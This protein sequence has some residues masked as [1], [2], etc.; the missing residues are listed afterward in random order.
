MFKT[1]R[2]P[3]RLF[4]VAM[5]LVSFLFAGF[6]IGLGGKIVGD[7][8]GVE[9]RLSVEQFL[10][11]GEAARDGVVRDSLSRLA[12]GQGA[13]RER[14]QL[15]LAAAA[16]AYRNA[17]STF[18]NWIAARQATTDPSQD[19]EVLQRT[20]E[21]DALKESERSA[22][23]EMN[24]LNGEQ[25]S[26]S[27]AIEEQRARFAVQLRDASGRYE[28]ARFWQELRVF[29]IRLLITLP[30]LLV[31]AWLV[32]RKRKSQ[33]WPLARGFVLFALFTFFVELVPYLPSYGGY[34]RYGVGVIASG[35]AGIYVIRAM[36]R[37]KARRAEEEQQTESERRRALPYEEANKRI[38][39]GVCPACERSIATSAAGAPA[40]FC[41]HCGLTLF[42]E[43][44]TCATRKN[45]FF[46]YCPACGASAAGT[47]VAAV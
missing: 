39:A 8:P 40:N 20:R 26:V 1:L 27:Q 29:A 44:L 38:A 5:W 30:L 34:V 2:V 14:A 10:R 24:R 13:A 47:E 3:E 25:L 43:C 33:Y 32:L 42:D 6:L 16:N 35:L 9:Q 28:G 17:R 4:H 19:P 23:L 45:A 41:V 11:P 31:A 12:R 15:R 22:Q 46:H 37:Y 21:L 18:D 7:L 36:Q